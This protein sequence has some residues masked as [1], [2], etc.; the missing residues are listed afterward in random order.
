MFNLFLGIVSQNVKLYNRFWDKDPTV[1]QEVY[2]KEFCQNK[3]NS[4]NR[5][6]NE[7]NKEDNSKN[8]F[9]KKLKISPHNLIFNVMGYSFL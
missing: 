4:H 5:I 9:I 3:T 7:C 8:D 6:F 1:G 2:Q